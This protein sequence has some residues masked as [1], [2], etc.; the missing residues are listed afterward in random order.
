VT[1]AKTTSLVEV[2]TGTFIGL[3]VAIITQIIIFP[4]FEIETNLSNNVQI[5]A[6]FTGVSILRGYLVRRAFN[7]LDS[8]RSVCHKPRDVQL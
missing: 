2:I 7:W 5:A 6:I 3:T 1:Q 8:H 4:W